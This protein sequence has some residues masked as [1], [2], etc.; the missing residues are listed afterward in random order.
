MKKNGYS[1]FQITVLEFQRSTMNK[2]LI[3]FKRL[4]THEEYAGAG[5]G[6]A[7]CKRIVE[8]HGGSIWV[9]SHEGEGTTF[10]YST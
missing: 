8:R 2:F 6:L 10:F 3:F 9:E 7:I 1:L 4:H 5:M